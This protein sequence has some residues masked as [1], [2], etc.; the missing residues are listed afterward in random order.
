MLW[1]TETKKIIRG[2]ITISSCK[3]TVYSDFKN[4]E[5]S[6]G[7]T[8][9]WNRKKRLIKRQQGWSKW[10]DE[11][12]YALEKIRL[13]NTLQSR[14]EMADTRYNKEYS[15]VPWKGRT[16]SVRPISLPV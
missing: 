12:V 11:W 3:S 8:E 9:K 10:F 14:T 7:H 6:V 4:W 15:H 16:G 13:T 2:N 1:V 5:K